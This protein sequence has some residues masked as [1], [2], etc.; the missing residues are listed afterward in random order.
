MPESKVRKKAADKKT[1]KRKAHENVKRK[2]NVSVLA[3]RGWVPYVFV[4]LG[5]LGVVWL[6]VFYIAGNDLALMS[7]LGNWNFLIG[8][9]LIAASFF[10]ATLWK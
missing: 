7:A 1:V 4:P 8:L 3:D 10:V 5:L 2:R 9:G 6:V